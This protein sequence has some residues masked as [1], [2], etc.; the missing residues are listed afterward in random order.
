MLKC[1]NIGI[2]VKQNSK[3]ICSYDLVHARSL[4]M[5][6]KSLRARFAHPYERAGNFLTLDLS[7]ISRVS[8]VFCPD[9]LSILLSYISCLSGHT[10]ILGWN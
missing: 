10:G 4:R 2:L 1:R 3:I 5:R 8:K 7:I 9:L 6:R